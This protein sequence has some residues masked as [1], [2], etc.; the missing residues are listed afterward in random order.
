LIVC[1]CGTQRLG[2]SVAEAISNDDE[3]DADKALSWLKLAHV[4]LVFV[5]FL[6]GVITERILA[7]NH[8]EKHRQA[9]TQAEIPSLVLFACSI[10]LG[11]I[12]VLQ[13]AY[14]SVIC[15][16]TLDIH[17]LMVV[18]VI[19]TYPRFHVYCH[20]LQVILSHSVVCLM[21]I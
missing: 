8:S 18:A 20:V 6:A 2:A 3:E 5:L 4:I 12:P 7:H 15:R 13:A 17:T 19:G 9:I 14:V 11:L 1:L 21:G 10:G 16:H